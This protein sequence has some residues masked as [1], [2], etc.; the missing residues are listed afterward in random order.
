MR[1]R[2]PCPDSSSGVFATRYDKLATN[3]LAFIKF[4]TIRIWLGAYYCARSI[5]SVD[6]ERVVAVAVAQSGQRTGNYAVRFCP[7]AS[8]CVF[9]SSLSVA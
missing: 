1:P 4:A 6:G 3:Y 9:C 2:P 8:N 5:A 7:I